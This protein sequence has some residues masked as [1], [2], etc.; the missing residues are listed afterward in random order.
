[1]A[2]IN[3]DRHSCAAFWVKGVAET[4]KA[5][6]LDVLALLE[7]AGLD[8]AALSD[9]DAR[10]PTERVSL[11]WRLAVAR[12]GNPA[13][14]LSTWSVVR[15]ASFDVVAYTMMS[16]PNLLGILK[17]VV[18]YVG[19]VSDA[20]SFAV[21]EDHEGCRMTL[22]L[23]GGG[24]P[25][26]RQRFEFDLMTFLS[27]CRW[28]TNRDLRPLAL[29]LRFPPPDDSQPY[30]DAFKCP[31]RFNATV[32]ALLFAGADVMA[33]LPTA[34]PLLAEVHERLASEH[35][36]RLDHAQTCSR[37]RAAILRRL[38]D[39]EPRRAKI[40]RELEMSE[41]TLQ[42]RLQAEGTSFQ[43]LL[44]DTRRE[45]AQQY[46]GQPDLSLADA[47]YLLGFRDLSS[48]FRTSKRWFGTSPRQ[49]RLRLIR[50]RRVGP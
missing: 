23:F 14:G 11:L 20:A 45:L 18:R 43:R 6:G 36:Q 50:A 38:A 48:F 49:Y 47:C 10:F 28:V 9:P 30:R 39:G 25:V 4:L 34:H 8:T 31:L 22:E 17:S 12:S 41:R 13:I 32:N 33:P 19:I 21:T 44:D 5:G 26:P 35:L 15:P 46:L 2:R 40:A 3:G 29:E 37:A 27:F 16:S 1:M 7:E 42:R 24:Q